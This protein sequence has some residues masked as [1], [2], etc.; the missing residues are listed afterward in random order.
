MLISFDTRVL[1]ILRRLSNPYSDLMGNDFCAELREPGALQAM[2]SD[3]LNILSWELRRVYQKPVVVLIDEYDS[4]MHS[5][6]DHGYAALVRSFILLYCS[7][8]MLFQANDFFAI[9]FGSLL[10]VCQH[11][12]LRHHRLTS[13]DRTMTRCMQV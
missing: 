9:V 3:A 6:I 12:R 7:Y 4:P 5:A 8:L 13:F 1:N 2:R 10:K 11:Q